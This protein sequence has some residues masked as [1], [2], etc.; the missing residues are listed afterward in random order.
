MA[1]DGRKLRQLVRRDLRKQIRQPAEGQAPLRFG[2][3]RA[4]EART[5]VAGPPGRFAPDARLADAGVADDEEAREAALGSLD[6]AV[7]RLELAAA[8]DHVT[9]QVPLPSTRDRDHGPTLRRALIN[10]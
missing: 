8:P 4:E 7:D 9:P 10:H 5:A 6:E 2:R 3:R 1:L